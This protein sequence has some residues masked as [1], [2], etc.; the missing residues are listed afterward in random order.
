MT[1]S[2]VTASANF[3]VSSNSCTSPLAP[4]A[5]CALAVTFTPPAAGAVSGT[6]TI[7][8]NAAFN[9]QQVVALSGTGAT[10][11]SLRISPTFV[12]FGNQIVNAVSQTQ[13]VTLTST[14]DTALAFPANSIRTGTGFILQST[15][16]GASL[17][18]GGIC[19]VDIQFEPTTTLLPTSGSLL[20]TDNAPGNPQAVYMEGTGV[21]AG[22]ASTTTTLASSLNPSTS[23]QAVTFTATVA[24]TAGSTP[25]PTGSV[26]FL[27]GTTTLAT[28]TV[29]SS[30]TAAYTATL[31]ASGS[32][33]ITAL[34][35][36]DTTYASSTSA[37][38]TQVVNPVAMIN[39][40]TSVSSSANP[41]TSGQAVTFTATV[42]APAG[43]TPSPTGSVTFLDGTTTLGATAL[44]PSG[45]AGFST[46]ALSAGTHQITAQYSGDTT[47][48]G[49][50][51]AALAQVVNAAAV[52]GFSL[53]V[54]P[55]TITVTPGQSGTVTLKVTPDNGFNQAVS[56]A[57]SGLPSEAAC[58]FSPVTVTPNGTAAS[59]TTMTIT[60]TAASTS[61]NSS[62]W[63]FAGG[64]TV[65]ALGLLFFRR[66]KR[67]PA[68]LCLTLLLG[69]SG[70]AIGCGGGATKPPGNTGTPAGTSTVTVIASSGSGASAI[71]QTAALTLTV[72]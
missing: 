44:T 13:T 62:P 58:S 6:L 8:D 11:P 54:S 49:S 41:S 69:I 22:S 33:S 26:T 20:I 52:P 53:S 19:T 47:Y 72:Q 27:D 40:T 1:V 59:S 37:V 12:N 16:C 70:M 68:L 29:S 28:V 42:T 66:K 15:T 23:G 18:P 35:S 24:G 7:A 65:L 4:N 60:T 21:Q 45:S 36:G 51:S 64:G 32:H 5:T 67:L 38:L 43:S 3:A 63:P 31:L 61:R 34:Y 39:T 9:S 2:S 55:A 71:T 56:F 10:G 25:A 30:G 17:P 14:G 48:A 50:T 57:C 46:S